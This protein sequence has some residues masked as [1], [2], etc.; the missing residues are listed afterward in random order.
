MA[1]QKKQKSPEKRRMQYFKA[2]MEGTLKIDNVKTLT[3]YTTLFTFNTNEQMNRQLNDLFTQ[4]LKNIKI[5]KPGILKY[6]VFGSTADP[7]L[8]DLRNYYNFRSTFSPDLIKY[9]RSFNQQHRS[10]DLLSP[11]KSYFMSKNDF[12]FSDKISSIE[13]D[14]VPGLIINEFQPDKVAYWSNF[15]FELSKNLSA[16]ALPSGKLPQDIKKLVGDAI[17]FAGKKFSADAS[18]KLVTMASAQPQSLYGT[19]RT[20][21]QEF[22]PLMLVKKL[23]SNRKMVK[24]I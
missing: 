21:N 19:R 17:T 11:S 14:S 18:N 10:D 13:T 22:D 4:Y 3:D 24:Y 15:V 1:E 23:F 8:I 20:L 2:L 9:M 12:L 16:A 5:D 7:V 6:K